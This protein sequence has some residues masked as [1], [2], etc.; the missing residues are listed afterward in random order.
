MSDMETRIEIKTEALPK[1]AFLALELS[2][3]RQLAEHLKL[4]GDPLKRIVLGINLL[5]LCHDQD[6]S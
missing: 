2:Q 1:S 4:L 5:C 6:P 3:V